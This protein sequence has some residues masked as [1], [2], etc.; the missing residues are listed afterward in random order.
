MI[1]LVNGVV[2]PSWSLLELRY[3]P[4]VITAPVLFVLALYLA[5][6]LRSRQTQASA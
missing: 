2:H 5:K 1:E 3:T 6:Q 4:G